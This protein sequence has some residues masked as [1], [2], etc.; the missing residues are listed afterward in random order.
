ME[1]DEGFIGACTLRCEMWCVEN[2]ANVPAVVPSSSLP[3]RNIPRGLRVP[4][5]EIGATEGGPVDV[6]GLS[7]T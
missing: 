2:L 6:E 4:A 3:V 1:E 5:D 7:R